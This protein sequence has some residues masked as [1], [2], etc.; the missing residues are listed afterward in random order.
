VRLGDV[1]K[2]ITNPAAVMRTWDTNGDGALSKI[3]FR[4]Q[5][6]KLGIGADY[7][8]TDALFDSLDTDGS[9]ELELGELKGA[10]RRLQEAAG[11]AARTAADETARLEES[12]ARLRLKSEHA[13]TV[14]STI[15]AA[16]R[17]EERLVA[18]KGAKQPLVVQLGEML[19]GKNVKPV[20]LL[21][22]WDA[23]SD[24]LISKGEFAT[25]IR[26]HGLQAEPGEV[27][28]VFGQLD[29]DGS[30]YIDLTEL[31]AVLRKLADA[32]REATAE[33]RAAE[34][35]AAALRAK[36][37]Q[38]ERQLMAMERADAE[39]ASRAAGEAADAAA[40]EAEEERQRIDQAAA[41]RATQKAKAE[42]EK[43]AFDAKVA[44]KRTIQPAKPPERSAMAALRDSLTKKTDAMRES[45]KK[46]SDAMRESLK[47][48]SVLTDL[49][50]SFKKGSSA[51]LADALRESFKRR[52][53]S[54]LSDITVSFKK[55][56][57]A[58]SSFAKRKGASFAKRDRKGANSFVK[59]KRG[60]RQTADCRKGM[61]PT[62]VPQDAE[63]VR[64][65]SSGMSVLAAAGADP[66]S[67]PQS[68]RL[69]SSKRRQS[70][71]PQP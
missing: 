8:E 66:T 59:G 52:R 7:R 67:A 27:E 54:V 16:E 51:V 3:E 2:S 50:E 53:S 24:G 25:S 17:E 46:G 10:V 43:Q 42:Q 21:R 5:V 38:S 15:E 32:M 6:R 63:H 39:A 33:L 20:E 19:R 70:A 56:L 62:A 34:Q 57:A 31:K 9:G 28:Q 55:S 69:K 41:R 64:R 26:K 11:V 65:P 36:S 49:R 45:F 29:E 35:K 44:R 1:L 58:G 37:A 13:Q 12:V 47:Q 60:A 30:G 14:L 61:P 22:S 23:N 18:L 71:D 68:Q 4:Q 40:R 48:G